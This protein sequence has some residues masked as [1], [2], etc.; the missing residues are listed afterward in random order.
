[1]S[2]VVAV[3]F[4]LRIDLLIRVIFVSFADD[5]SY[6]FHINFV[7]AM[8]ALAAPNVDVVAHGD[9]TMR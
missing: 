6:H 2:H 7:V 9:F 5:C 4:L 1:M 8:S 3:K